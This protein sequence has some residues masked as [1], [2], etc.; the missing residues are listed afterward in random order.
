MQEVL[1]KILDDSIS[2]KK[3]IVTFSDWKKNHLFIQKY[4][5]AIDFNWLKIQNFYDLKWT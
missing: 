2:E 4:S 5:L 3:S 1:P